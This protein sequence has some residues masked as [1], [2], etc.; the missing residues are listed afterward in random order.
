VLDANLWI[1]FAWADEPRNSAAVLVTGDDLAGITACAAEIARSYWDA[2]DDFAVV[3]DRNG[4]IDEAYDFL[5][6]E[7]TAGT[8]FISDS[9]DNVTAGSTGDITFALRR[10]LERDDLAGKN[11]FF[12]GFWDP[13]ALAAAH[14]AGVGAVLDRAIGAG[15]DDRY[16]DPVAGPWTVVELIE[17]RFYPGEIVGAVLT[18]R[19]VTVSVQSHRAFFADPLHPAFTIEKRPGIAWSEPVG[20]DAVIVKNGYL[21]P[22]QWAFASSQFM[23]ITPGGTDLDFERL[24]IERWSRPMYPLDTDF[25]PDLGV[26]ILP[27]PH[28]A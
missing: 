8:T 1:G 5:L 2:R 3:G 10:A 13:G 20:A 26:V 9:G 18:G 23:A 15:V 16:G 24:P 12:A 6:A 19:G 28:T 21:F 4:T 25:E 14:D 11:L 7:G 27:A 22:S 17:D